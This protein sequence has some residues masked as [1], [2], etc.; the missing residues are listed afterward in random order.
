MMLDAVCL[1]AHLR[2]YVYLY[3]CM[4]VCMYAYIHTY[5]HTCTLA[6]CACEHVRAC[7]HA[8]VCMCVRVFVCVLRACACGCVCAV[9]LSLNSLAR[10]PSHRLS[11]PPA[12]AP[13]L[14]LLSSLPLSLS[15][16]PPLPLSLFTQYMCVCVCLCLSVCACVY[17]GNAG[18]RTGVRALAAMPD[19]GWRN[20][21]QAFE[22]Q[23]VRVPTVCLN[24]SVYLWCAS[25]LNPKP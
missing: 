25:M 23:Y 2:V 20:P 1:C 7:E 15:P 10:A 16:S 13:P 9:L 5:I 19:A 6:R 11:C 12:L 21:P 14:S 17:T 3:I 18:A 22:S 8:P 4:Y 24:P